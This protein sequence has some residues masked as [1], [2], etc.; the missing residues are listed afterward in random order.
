MGDKVTFYKGDVIEFILQ[1]IVADCIKKLTALEPNIVWKKKESS[2]T[3]YVKT[4]N[5]KY[6]NEILAD[7][8]SQELLLG[9]LN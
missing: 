1:E 8:S 4:K 3:Q 9:K 5:S 7:G 2:I 6:L